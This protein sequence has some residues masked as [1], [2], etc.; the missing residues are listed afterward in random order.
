MTR[1]GVLLPATDSRRWLERPTPTI[2]AVVPAYN[3]EERIGGVIDAI[4]QSGVA[5]QLIVVSDGSTD[6]T[7]EIARKDRGVEAY[8]LSQNLGKAGAMFMGALRA[9]TD[10]ILFL[11]ADL[12]GLTPDHVHRLV[13]PIRERQADMAVGTFC[14]GRFLTDLAQTIAPAITGQRVVS[15]DFFLSL[16]G[17]SDVR[18]GVEMA[19]GFHARRQGLRI[20]NVVLHG[21]THPMK[22]EKLGPLKGSL[23]RL[24]MYYEMGRYVAVSSLRTYDEP[25]TR[26]SAYPH[27]RR[28]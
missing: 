24:K 26:R 6:R 11:D 3:E 13:H 27:N 7:Y 21:V 18:Y 9:R 12:M 28:I 22:E 20:S 10:C 4:R 14:G 8:Q 25:E 16:P 23:A 17:I 15:R 5:D 19:I 2:A 1:G